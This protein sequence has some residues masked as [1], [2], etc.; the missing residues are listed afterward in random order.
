MTEW[1]WK[2]KAKRNRGD[3]ETGEIYEDVPIVELAE[4]EAKLEN[5]D[6]AVVN[7]RWMIIALE[8]KLAAERQSH[9][10]AMSAQIQETSALKIQLAAAE[11]CT[12]SHGDL[13]VVKQGR[14]AELEAALRQRCDECDHD[15]DNELCKYCKWWAIND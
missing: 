7:Q 3:V 15:T 11:K 9:E 13:L 14:I 6:K 10:L 5:R 4:A 8:A 1:E 2:G 12:R